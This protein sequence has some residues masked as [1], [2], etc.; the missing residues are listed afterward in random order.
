MDTHNL[1]QDKRAVEEGLSGIREIDWYALKRV[2]LTELSFEGLIH[3]GSLCGFN[4]E[5]IRNMAEHPERCG[6]K[7]LS[8]CRYMFQ[9]SGY[10]RRLVKYYSTMPKYRWTVD[11]ELYSERP[12]NVKR[13][14]RAFLQFSSEVEKL[15]LD[16]E[17]ERI[18]L[19]LFRDD[20]CFGYFVEADGGSFLYYL[21]PELCEIKTIA[22]GVYGFAIHV[23]RISLRELSSYPEGLKQL[24]ESAKRE[25]RSWVMVPY[26]NAFCV[27]YHDDVPYLFPP[28]FHLISDILDIVDYKELAKAKTE[29]DCYRLVALKIP[30]DEKGQIA[31][32][33][34]II[35]PF[36]QMTK[37]IL[38]KT[39]GVV[40]TPMELS[41]E[42]FSSDQAER[43]RVSDA[44]SQMYAEA[45]VSEALMSGATSGSE[46]ATAIKA[47]AGEVYRLYRQIERNV[48]LHLMLRGAGLFSEYRFRF[49]MLDV[50]IFNEDEVVDR[51]L[52]LAQASI[53]NKLRLVGAV[54]LSPSR[55]LG[56]ML[57]ENELFGLCSAW[58][59]LKSSATQS[60]DESAN[61]GRPELADDE[62]SPSGETTR[63]NEANDAD[64]R[65]PEA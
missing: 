28:L 1:E 5:A 29:Q 6:K 3:G 22:N 31:L 14:K 9:S 56:N 49:R 33:D 40:P 61:S 27:K 24:I 60:S 23:G 45:G 13:L 64:N 55:M 46:L 11:T 34:E 48:E 25:G 2:L 62:L 35:T 65:A 36:V 57:V 44:T 16:Y 51:E 21:R 43:D 53:P 37:S 12:G 19:R 8:L 32:G 20:V 15:N 39:I 4:R 59:V 17:L 38:P 26:E 10:Y 63:E 50:T 58:E 52:K 41:T 47:D 54:G 30:T 42:Q 18:F 7:I